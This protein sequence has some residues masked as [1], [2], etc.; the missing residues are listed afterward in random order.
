VAVTRH[1]GISHIQT[2]KVSNLMVKERKK[3]DK[4]KVLDRVSS[5]IKF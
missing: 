1:K 5:F 3:K 4:T 2:K